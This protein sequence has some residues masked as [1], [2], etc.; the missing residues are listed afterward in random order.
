MNPWMLLTKYRITRCCKDSWC[1]KW[2]VRVENTGDR[3]YP[4]TWDTWRQ[5]L[6]EVVRRQTRQFYF[7]T[8]GRPL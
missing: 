5:A 7:L 3:I 4:Y 6:D 1:R 8:G 2:T